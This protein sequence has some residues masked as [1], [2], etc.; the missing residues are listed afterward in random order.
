MPKT[1]TIDKNTEGGRLRMARK[2]RGITLQELAT[3]VGCVHSSLQSA[4]SGRTSLRDPL[5]RA[6]A[7]ELEVSPDWIRT[8]EGPRTVEAQ[9]EAEDPILAE[10][11]LRGTRDGYRRRLCRAIGKMTD[12]QV[13]TLARLCEVVAGIEIDPPTPEEK[14]EADRVRRLERYQRLFAEHDR[15]TIETMLSMMENEKTGQG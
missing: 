8:G 13:E 5:L 4:E 14:A 1:I 11:F 6:V 3:R 12:D 9:V 2:D 15:K 7:R 10:Y